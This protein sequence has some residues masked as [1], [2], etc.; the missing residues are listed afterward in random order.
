MEASPAGIRYERETTTLV[1]RFKGG[2]ITYPACIAAL[3]AALAK[4][5]LTLDKNELPALRE[6]M[7]ANN[8]EVVKEMERRGPQKD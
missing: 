4:V 1:R 8:A 5:I 3:D 7:M 2:H 6:L